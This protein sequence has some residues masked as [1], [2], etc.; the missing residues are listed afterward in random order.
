MFENYKLEIP[1]HVTGFWRIHE[2]RD[3]LKTGST[4]AG[5]V[6]KPRAKVYFLRRGETLTIT[7]NGKVLNSLCV[8]KR[9][10]DKLKTL[11]TKGEVKVEAK[12]KLGEGYAISA[13]LAISSAIGIYWLSNNKIPLLK[14]LRVA[15][16]SEVECRTG[17]GDVI[18]I[19]RGGG[20]EIRVKPGPP[21]I[22]EVITIPLDEKLKILGVVIKRELN[23]PTML[24]RYKDKINK[25][26]EEFLRELLK[27][28]T[29]EKFL[30]LSKEF[31]IRTGMLKGKLKEKIAFLETY[32]KNGTIQGYYL[33]KNTLIVVGWD[34]L[35]EVRE[36][37]K[38]RL[39]WKT[40]SLEVSNEGLKLN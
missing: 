21:G 2:S 9:V 1:L 24:E 4:G 27:N 11:T 39:K 20:L 32:M 17:L 33:K 28:P 22:G 19:Y 18:A 36:E 12:P 34:N 5:L 15:H 30:E 26:G 8:V 37:F 25:Y 14:A 7:L 29:L 23:T 13:V 40:Y 3:P 10:M 6:L 35:S 31:S 38:K 16:E